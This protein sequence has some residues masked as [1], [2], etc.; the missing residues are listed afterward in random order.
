MIYKIE[1]IGQNAGKIWE[2]LRTYGEMDLTYIPKL[3]GVPNTD[4]Y[5]ALGWLAK[6]NKVKPK[7]V[8]PKKPQLHFGLK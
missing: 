7:I 2:L 8:K 5:L 3:S 6:E 1:D 4:A